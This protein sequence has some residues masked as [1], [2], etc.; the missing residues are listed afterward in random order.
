MLSGQEQRDCL[1]KTKRR[2]LNN[3]LAQPEIN[4]VFEV[5]ISRPIDL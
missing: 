5:E 3:T 4:L 2:R 1:G